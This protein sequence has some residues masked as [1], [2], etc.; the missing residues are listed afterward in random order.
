MVNHHD[1][2]RNREEA[3]VLEVPKSV[4]YSKTDPQLLTIT[5]DQPGKG[6]LASVLKTVCTDLEMTNRVG[7]TDDSLDLNRC[8]RNHP[9]RNAYVSVD[10][11]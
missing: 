5:L 2:T 4:A 7:P 8:F 1:Q 9:L 3:P 11:G 6:F 10:P